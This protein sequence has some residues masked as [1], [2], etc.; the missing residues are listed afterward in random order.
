MEVIISFEFK[1]ADLPISKI[2]A[3]ALYKDF[4]TLIISKYKG[5][6]EMLSTFIHTRKSEDK[7]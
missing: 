7:K 3:D 1:V 5:D 2:N 6:V 4:E